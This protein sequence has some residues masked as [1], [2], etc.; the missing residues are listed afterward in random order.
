MTEAPHRAENTA[1]QAHART[2]RPLA[3][4]LA[5]VVLVLA[6]PI[7]P[8]VLAGPALEDRVR[9]WFHGGFSPA[10]TAGM[11]VALLAADV[12]LPVPSSFVSTFAAGVL[13]FPL[14]TAASW[15]GMTLGAAIAFVLARFLGRP[16]ALWLSGQEDLDR[17]DRLSR[18][19]GAMV[20]VLA[21]PVP[22]LAEASVLFLATT[23]LPWRWFLLPIMLS[24]L[25]VAA[26]YSALGTAVP[27]PVALAASIALPLA[28]AAAARRWWP[29]EARGASGGA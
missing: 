24:N 13:G 6:V 19:Y 28:A 4:T 11:V 3:V 15:L 2:A 21:R 17:V 14:A 5:L 27:M 20:L 22:V 1:G 8:F 12:L 25:G 9:G 26:V 23:R 10:A 7:V 18:R 29:A 16:A